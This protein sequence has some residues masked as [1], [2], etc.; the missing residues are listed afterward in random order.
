M[1]H[2]VSYRAPRSRRCLSL[3]LALAGSAL[4]H[5][6]G[7][8][9]AQDRQVTVSVSEGTNM[10]A[11]LSPDGSMIAIDL[12]GT[13]WTLPAAGGE[14]TAI[15]DMIGDIR[16][17]DWSPDG[18]RI[19]FQSFRDG[20]WHLWSTK[21]D[22]SDLQQHTFGPYDDREPVWSPDGRSIAFSSDR[23]GNYDV[24]TLELASGAVTKI[25]DAPEDDFSPVFAPD[26]RALAYAST[27][28]SGG[29]RVRALA[30]GEG[31]RLVARAGGATTPSWSPDGRYLVFPVTPRG[32]ASL[33]AVEVGDGA[34]PPAEPVRLSDDGSDV[35][36]FRAAWVSDTEFLYT[37]DGK[38]RRGSVAGIGRAGG[39]ADATA[40]G[41]DAGSA[42]PSADD[43]I[44]FRA[45]FSFTRPAYER[46][47]RDFDSTGPQPVLGIFGPAVSPSGAQVAFTAL[48]D[49]WLLDI[50]NPTP[51]R[52]TDDRFSDITPAWSRDGSRLAY[53]SDR[54]GTY[55]LW[56]RDMATGEERRVTELAGS[57]TM[58]A[59]S[60][61]GRSLVFQTVLG[62]GTQLHLL[63]LETGRTRILR[64]DL[65]APSRPSW[66]GDGSTLA[67]SVLSPYSSRFREGRNE[68]LLQPVD[69][70]EARRVTP[71]EHR[72]IGA[73]AMDGP[74][75]SPDGRKMA[76]VTDGVLWV[77][78]VD[79]DGDPIAPPDRLTPHSADAISW[80]GDSRSIVYQTV[81]GLRRVS[82]D[83]GRIE[84]I[85]LE[86]EWRR[87]HPTGTV[88]VHAGRL[89]D[90]LADE[91]RENVDVVIEGHRVARVVPHDEA[92]HV[93][94]VVDAGDHTV[95]P[96]L[97]DMHAHI[98]FGFGETL[99]RIWL[100]YGV[101][102][103]RDPSSDAYD[104]RLRRET[105]E[106]GVRAGPREFATGRLM[107]GTR[108]YYSFAT[109]L[110]R[111]AQAELEL[112]RADRLDYS[113]IKTY[114]RLPD[115][116]QK[117]IIEF[118][119]SKGIPV[120]SHE[121]YPA[122]AL[123][124][125]HVEHIR[126]TSRRGY[127]PKVT[128]TNHS[129]EDVIQLLARSGM[130]ITPTTG[131]QGAW[132]IV[133]SDDSTYTADRRFQTLFP[134]PLI[135]LTERMRRARAQFGEGLER[136]LAPAGET[137]RRVV[138]AGGRVVAGT[139]APII[140]YGVSLHAEIEHYVRS[141][142]TPAQALRTATSVA[143][144]ALNMSGQI[145][146]VGE[147]A[148]AD[149][150]V[151]DGDPLADI[152]DARKVV[153]TIKNGE[154]FRMEDLLQPASPAIVP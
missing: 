23:S 105:V 36:P 30:G 137:V 99:G 69:G 55:D 140:P 123:G 20:N 144:E 9:A 39:P 52:L 143:A 153:L 11:A 24:W 80:T 7:P 131:I 98:G 14:A 75:W 5:I 91:A 113:L 67:I 104:M 63:D 16:Q 50:G 148:L 42:A 72:G 90:G 79:G 134:R 65:F 106:A 110:D 2:A 27:R 88:T 38:I 150:V 82:L 125:D 124:A 25:T 102:T 73:R 118:A 60:P 84:E 115:L 8:V 119:H 47:V 1:T 87:S 107:D 94:E 111:S 127:S 100:A 133:I 108:I 96:G 57:E 83:D 17:P 97:I 6:A 154:L 33:M 29:I 129:Y 149:L 112:D 28:E 86:L 147:G 41:A 44:E 35:F 93:G 117:R 51:L 34:D 21:P 130:T 85:P 31:D 120:S 126:G 142:L 152:T 89:W 78:D 128:G 46:R 43:P 95:M 122:V 68:I 136:S 12:Q 37:A 135:E 19:A 116:M 64:N 13:L 132:P 40:R 54:A 22:G 32:A 3:A 146:T 77:V 4:A 141:G 53:A 59:W 139:D 18:A 74:V 15:S 45:T 49:L 101:T 114:V 138:E 26:G 81:D 103:I 151:V 71:M 62:L 109:S 58:P 61:D 76:F 56:V 92:N 48:G 121:L 66:S 145:G 10:A 70:G